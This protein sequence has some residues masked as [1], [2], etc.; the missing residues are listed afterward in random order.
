MSM[1]ALMALAAGAADLPPAPPRLDLTPRAAVERGY[2]PPSP[3]GDSEPRTAVDHRFTRQGL[4][5]EAGYLCGIGGIGPDA[6]APGGGP[7]SLW[8]HQG[9]FLGAKLGYP[10]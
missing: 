7:S 6:A 2:A 9:T 8:N 4:T 1:L 10:F 5:G 3:T